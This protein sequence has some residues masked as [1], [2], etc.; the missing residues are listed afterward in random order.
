MKNFD[1]GL[2]PKYTKLFFLIPIFILNNY[3]T[4][5]KYYSFAFIQVSNRTITIPG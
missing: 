1:N 4:K 5:K 2:L 3:K